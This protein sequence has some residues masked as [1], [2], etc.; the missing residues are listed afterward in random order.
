MS[1]FPID[2][3]ELIPH[4]APFLFLDEITSIEGG[5]GRARWRVKPDEHFFAGH[6]PGR[7]VVP[8]VVLIEAIAQLAA[9][10]QAHEARAAGVAPRPPILTSVQECTIER[11]LGPG[12]E[13]VVESERA[14]V[15]FG[16]L[17][18]QGRVRLASDGALV[19]EARLRG[20]LAPEGTTL[21]NPPTH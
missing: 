5:R 2:P 11:P 14:W 3:R 1:A 8:G 21:T 16:T 15:R 12:D 7:P 19:A 10:V 9:A 17:Q 6:F 20:A 18:A 4:R 13:V